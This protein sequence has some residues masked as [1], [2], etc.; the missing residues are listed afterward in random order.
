MAIVFTM[1]GFGLFGLM[2][3]YILSDFF[4]ALM[5]RV[6][7]NFK[8]PLDKMGWGIPDR[9]LFKQMFIFGTTYMLIIITSRLSSSTDNLVIGIALGA[10]TVAVYYTSQMPGTLLYQ[11]IWKLAD[12]AYPGLNDLYA[13]RQFDKI[14]VSYLR[15]SSIPWSSAWDCSWACCCSTR[16]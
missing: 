15:C 14:Q 6:Y 7:Y 16:E 10:S 2:I 5:Q 12:S 9:T 8:F 13:N 4:I 3:A 11:F 1:L